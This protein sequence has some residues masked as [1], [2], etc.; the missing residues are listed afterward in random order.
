M[1]TQKSANY[2]WII[3]ICLLKMSASMIFD[4]QHSS[5]QQNIRKV[6][7]INETH[8]SRVHIIPS[9]LLV[10]IQFIGR[11]SH[12]TYIVQYNIQYYNQRDREERWRADRVRANVSHSDRQSHRYSIAYLMCGELKCAYNLRENTH[13]T[14]VKSVRAFHSQDTYQ[15]SEQMKKTK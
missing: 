6:A 4:E 11:A 14:R 1:A 9:G 12:N 13:N 5:K 3:F 8:A 2:C 10:Q 15:K 7:T